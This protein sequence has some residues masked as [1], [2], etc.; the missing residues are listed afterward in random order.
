VSYD[1]E[2]GARNLLLNCAG[3][4]PGDRLLLVGEQS[5]LPFFDS[6]LCHD[7]ADIASGLGIDSEILLARPVVDASQFPAEVSAAMQ[8]VD[9][10][11]FFSRLGDQI[12]FSQTPG[13]STKIMTYTLSREHL[14]SAFATV[15]YRLMHRIH[16]H[17]FTK[18]KGSKTYRI[19]S[20]NGTSLNAELPGQ[21]GSNQ[22]VA[23]DFTVELF[24]VMIFP[25]I[26]FFRLNGQLV[27]EHFLLSSSTRAYPDSVLYLDSAVTVEVEDSCMVGFDGDS[28][29]VTR[30]QSQ[31]ERAAGLT[32]GD[33]YRLNSWHT[34][35]NP[36]TFYNGDLHANLEQWGTVTY[37]SPRYTHIHAAGNDPGDISIQLFDA[38]ISFDGEP[39]WDGGKFTYLDS[40]EVQNLLGAK[41]RELFNSSILLDIGI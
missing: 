24:P 22:P 7:V 33:P 5:T 34:G 1:I 12:R 25:P 39:F 10:T 16:D 32:G 31:L 15:D 28:G 37:G 13:N 27:L 2:A 30:L 9:I 19:E 4:R 14:G 6:Q 41:E 26:T 3:A 20:A 36:Y 29:L 17:L 23:S 8:S 18:I 40:P 11:I 38:S 35:I 21:T